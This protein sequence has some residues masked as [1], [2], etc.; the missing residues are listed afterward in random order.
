MQKGSGVI[1]LQTEFNYLNSFT[2]Y[3]V[4][5]IWASSAR[6]GWGRWVREYLGTKKG[7][8]TC[9]HACVHI[10][11]HAYACNTKNYMLRNCKWPLPW[12]QPC[13]SWLTCMGMCVYMYLCMHTCVHVHTYVY[14]CGADTTHPHCHPPPTC[15]GGT[16]LKQYKFNTSWTN[17]VKSILFADLKSV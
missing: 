5:T 7:F 11:T 6:G 16:P 15:Q 14:K 2:F 17:R 9:K 3:R 13:L 4:F 10:C 12:R 8:P 1:N